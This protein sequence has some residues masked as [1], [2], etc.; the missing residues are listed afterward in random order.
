MKTEVKY[1]ALVVDDEAVI[2]A[3]TMRALSRFGFACFPA[4]DGK[5]ASQL[6]SQ[7]HYDVVV[8]DLRMPEKN[9]HTLAVELTSRNPRPIIVVLTG[10]A[11]P[12]LTEDLLL[13]GV[14]D[15]QF[16]PVQFEV[17]AERVRK[18]ADAKARSTAVQKG[19]A[20]ADFQAAIPA[21]EANG[22]S[23]GDEWSEVKRADVQDVVSA[24][25]GRYTAPPA[26]FDGFKIT[27]SNSLDVRS[28]AAAIEDRPALALEVLRLANGVFYQS[29]ERIHELERTVKP[30]LSAP[31]Q[32]APATGSIQMILGGL[33]LGWILSW[34]GASVLLFKG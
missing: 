1:S 14:D 20:V 17:F 29:A 25:R 9:G 6:L 27:S 19:F 13:R 4:A 31:E 23:T 15:V 5:E 8:T 32:S 10:V 16:K 12:K 11:E 18:L 28:L 3:G 22:E 33:A 21:S 26:D 30:S 34:V 24:I 2:R 7:S